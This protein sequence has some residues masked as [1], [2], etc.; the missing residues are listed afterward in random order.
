[1]T[2]TKEN[3]FFIHLSIKRERGDNTCCH[4]FGSPNFGPMWWMGLDGE[5]APPSSV[6]GGWEGGDARA[7]PGIG[8]RT[9]MS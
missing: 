6:W 3:H 8:E 7:G 2:N 1:M 5:R 9:K 4:F